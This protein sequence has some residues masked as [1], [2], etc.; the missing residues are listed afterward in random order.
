[1]VY[2]AASILTGMIHDIIKVF[3]IYI[4]SFMQVEGGEEVVQDKIGYQGLLWLCLSAIYSRSSNVK[5]LT[6]RE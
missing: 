2:D 4:A 1:M 6:V 3:I 5:G